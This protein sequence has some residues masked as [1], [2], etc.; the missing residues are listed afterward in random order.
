MWPQLKIVHGKLRYSQIQESVERANRNVQDI[1]R[2]WM[3]DNK[4]NKWR[5]GLRF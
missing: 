2:A 3:S 5:E 1:L 4:S